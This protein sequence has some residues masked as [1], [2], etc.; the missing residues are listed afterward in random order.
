MTAKD[1]A[2]MEQLLVRGSFWMA[3]SLV[4]IAVGIVHFIA[5]LI[6]MKW[7]SAKQVKEFPGPS[8]H[9]LKGNIKDVSEQ[10]LFQSLNFFYY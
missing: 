8:T 5:S 3:M 4:V 1:N 6:A 7:R 9:W 10:D 2:D